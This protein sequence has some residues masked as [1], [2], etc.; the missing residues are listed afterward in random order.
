MIKV[1]FETEI[2]KI[3]RTSQTGLWGSVA[4]VISDGA[5]PVCQSVAFHADRATSAVGC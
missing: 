1:M 5:L 2:K 4:V 3:K